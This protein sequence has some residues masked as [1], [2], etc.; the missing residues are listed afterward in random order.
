MQCPAHVRTLWHNMLDTTKVLIYRSVDPRSGATSHRPV[1]APLVEP[2]ASG[3]IGQWSHRPVEPSANGAI[4]LSQAKPAVWNPITPPR[5]PIISRTHYSYIRLIS[6][7]F[8]AIICLEAPAAT[9]SSPRRPWSDTGLPAFGP[10]E[11]P[12]ISS[13]IKAR[14]IC[15]YC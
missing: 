10:Q 3:A 12:H 6:R 5:H 2:S 11:P 15:V 14:F 13:N 8:Q 1:L 7:H 4:G 9:V